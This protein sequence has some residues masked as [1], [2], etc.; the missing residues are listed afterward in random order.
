MAKRKR[1][2]DP[3]GALTVRVVRPFDRD[4]SS[5]AI[6]WR[7]KRVPP[8]LG[9]CLAYP[10]IDGPGLGLLVFFPPILFL[11]T[12]PIFDVIAVLEPLK[13]D[14]ALGL[15]VVPVMVPVVFSFSM[16][17]GY[18]LL[19]LGHVLVSSA[20]GENDHPRWPEWH[21]ADIAEGIFRWIWACLWGAGIVA[22]PIA[23]YW[24]NCGEVDW[25]DW[26]VICVLTLLGAG[27]SLMVLAA[28]LLHENVLI[29]NPVTVFAAI[30]RIGSGY[31]WLCVAAGIA[32]GLAALGVWGLLY[33]MPRMWIEA[34]ALWGYWVFF[35]YMAMAM[36]RMVGLMCYAH[37]LHLSWF[38]R[39]PTWATSVRDGRIYSN[40]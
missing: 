11:L 33:K 22:G 24:M 1:W 36:L 30:A 12:L 39:K 40:S 9:E 7:H 31:L 3:D 34:V 10:L 32:V 16:T 8:R 18:A 13:G 20:L 2:Y 17:F 19:F 25:A 37:A 21:P 6:R 28:S 5:C 4:E 29:A 26:V 23:L 14:W 38:R 27:Y 35:L 15:L